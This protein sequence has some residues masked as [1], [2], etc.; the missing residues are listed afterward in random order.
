MRTKVF[1][2]IQRMPLAFFTRVQTGALVS[3]LNNDVTGAQ[4][5]F[6]N[7][8]S[9]IVGN[10]ITVILVLA[11]MFFLSWKLTLIALLLLPIF[12]IPA[13][14]LGRR[15]QSITREKY[16]L[17]AKMNT[18]MVEH[19][20]VAG[21]LLLKLFGHPKKESK[22]FA[23]KAGRVRDIGVMQTLYGRFFNVALTLQLPLPLP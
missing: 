8:L 18:T 1:N 22:T 13:G 11:A 10:L 9:V 6:T 19:F 17:N 20:N 3:R 7:L 4:E 5:S 12:I 23:E 15:L 14:W 2:Q 21:A 16:E